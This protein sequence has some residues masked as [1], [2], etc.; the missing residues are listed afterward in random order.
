VKKGK[1]MEAGGKGNLLQDLRR[2]VK[3]VSKEE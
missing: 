3:S 2:Q 1:G